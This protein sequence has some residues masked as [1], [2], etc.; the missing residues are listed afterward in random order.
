[1]CIYQI[2]GKQ[3]EA[4]LSLRWLQ[5]RF[6]LRFGVHLNTTLKSKQM[7]SVEKY[8]PFMSTNVD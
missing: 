5:S 7:E 4:Q 3:F 1:M 6:K 2:P 8:N